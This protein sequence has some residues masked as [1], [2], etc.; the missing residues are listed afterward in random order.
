MY[1]VL[2]ILEPYT[3]SAAKIAEQKTTADRKKRSRFLL[4]FSLLFGF[5]L[6][7]G[8]PGTG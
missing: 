3:P 6:L 8:F 1:T 4:L 2:F 5:R 7:K